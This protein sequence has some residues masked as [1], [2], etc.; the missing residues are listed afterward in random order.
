[1]TARRAAFAAAAVAGGVAVALVLAEAAVRV[2][3]LEPPSFGALAAPSTPD[4]SLRLLCYPTDPGRAFP[5][6]LRDAATFRRYAGLP[7]FGDLDGVRRSAP[8]CRPLKANRDRARDRE[9]AREKP[10]GV[11]RVLCVGDSL[12]HGYGVA[13]DGPWP[14]QLEALLAARHPG[15]RFEVMNYGRVGADLPQALHQ[16]MAFATAYRPDLVIYGFCLNDPPVSDALR[17]RSALVDSALLLRQDRPLLPPPWERSAL[18]RTIAELRYQARVSRETEAWYRDA[19]SDANRDGLARTGALLRDC[20]DAARAAGAKFLLAVLPL[21]ARFDDGYP[22]RGGHE[23]VTRLAELD[24]I[25]AVDLLPA[26]AG[27]DPRRLWL[28]PIDHHPNAEAYRIIAE[29]LAPTVERELGL[30]AANP[31]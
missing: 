22:A 2:L 15:R 16:V 25:D 6:D 30:D 19:Y 12:T 3:S 23:L 4:E 28:H 20:R 13:D 27:R 7:G 24:G 17:A 26:F 11:L 18:A 1:M 14:R 10:A 21:M 8:F 29:A 9:Y 5:V 31:R